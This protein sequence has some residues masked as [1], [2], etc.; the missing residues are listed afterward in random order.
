MPMRLTALLLLAA[1]AS[2]APSSFAQS[3][4]HALS[5][6]TNASNS[7]P[8]AQPAW[9]A[10]IEARRKQLISSNGYGT[11]SPLRDQLMKMRATDQAARGFAAASASKKEMVQNLPVTDAQ[12]T[13]E[14]KQIVSEKGWPTIAMVGIDASNAAMLILTHT[15]DHAWQQQMLPQLTQ[16]ADA[17]KI[18]PSSLALVVDKSLVSAGKLQRYGSQFKYINGAMAMYGVED[19]GGLDRKRARALLPPIDVYKEQLSQIYHLPASKAIVS[20]TPQPQN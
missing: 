11:D 13:A 12:L 18:D 14:L 2:F 19:P 5:A 17:D 4:A 6:A 15:P 1:S 7:E 3:G 10:A 20:A 8:A 9:K 16:L